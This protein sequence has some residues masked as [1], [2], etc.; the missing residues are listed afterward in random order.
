MNRLH[1]MR[2]Q[3]RMPFKF[4]LRSGFSL[5][6]LL[7]A[8]AIISLIMFTGFKAIA[9]LEKRSGE[10]QKRVT[11]HEK[12][13]IIFNS[14]YAL[15][16]SST[17][18]VALIEKLNTNPQAYVTGDNIDIV[19]D[20]TLASA[21][22]DSDS[23]KLFLHDVKMDNPPSLK[24]RVINISGNCYFKTGT[25]YTYGVDCDNPGEASTLNT[26][27]GAIFN[28]H[29]VLEMNIAMLDGRVC[30]V[31]SYNADGNWTLSPNSQ[32]PASSATKLATDSP[33]TYFKVP[34]I[35]IFASGAS[36]INL[37]YAR[38]ILENL[39]SPR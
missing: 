5:I 1:R 23:K 18:N 28:T 32:C 19:V 20:N 24:Y 12:A 39:V 9:M 2:L 36:A 27:M 34:R 17:A 26:E 25:A 29:G 22:G 35:I 30:K 13:E 38:T 33:T 7:V 15:Y 16:H 31:I 8:M 11:W 14:F 10:A 21:T 4:N 3:K 37:K 6:E